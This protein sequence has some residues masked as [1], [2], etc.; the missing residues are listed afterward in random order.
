MQTTCARTWESMT[1][2]APGGLDPGGRDIELGQGS[3]R[4]IDTMAR[5]LVDGAAIPMDW[6]LDTWKKQWPTLSE[7][8]MPKA[9]Q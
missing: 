9:P 2:A 8:P 5:A 6:L 3:S 1:E 7:V 4:R